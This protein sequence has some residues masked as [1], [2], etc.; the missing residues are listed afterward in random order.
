MKIEKIIEDRKREAL[1]KGLY[2][3]AETIVRYLTES[4]SKPEK[5]P[6]IAQIDRAD[7]D[8]SLWFNYKTTFEQGGLKINLFRKF[9]I[10]LIPALVRVEENE[11]IVFEAYEDDALGGKM[12][13]QTQIEITGYVPKEGWERKVHELYI[14]ADAIKQKKQK[15]ETEKEKHKASVK[16]QERLAKFGL[17]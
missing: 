8:G 15:E 4:D 16:E 13:P 14:E 5:V 10:F 11:K 1:G 17:S 7:S 3:K 9:S 12:R 6:D 2:E